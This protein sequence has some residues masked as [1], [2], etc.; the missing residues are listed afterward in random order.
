MRFKDREHAGRELA[1]RLEHLRAAQ[2]V[3]LGLTR[4]GI[5]VAFE[6]ARLLE[7]PLD[8]VVIRKVTVPAA[9]ER[10]FAAIAEGGETFLNPVVVREAG[11]RHEEAVALA[12]EGV[13]ELARR[14][15]L[16]RDG[17]PAPRLAQRTVVVVD[18]FAMTG[19]SVRAAARAARARGAKR[20]VLAIPL[21]AAGAEEEVE[22]DFDE[23]VALEVPAR[24]EGAAAYYERFEEVPDDVAIAYLR[25]ARSERMAEA[26]L[27]GLT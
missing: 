21:L 5:P 27:P 1:A 3:V 14:V 16:Y 18:D 8:L 26:A 22:G 7:A 19:T 10:T 2:P 25:R 20:V 6:V 12:R 17:I 23:V 24:W 13:D 4:G 15:R 11:Y 9:P